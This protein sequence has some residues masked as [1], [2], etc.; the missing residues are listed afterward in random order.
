MSINIWQ[1]V[2]L[3]RGLKDWEFYWWR[4]LHSYKKFYGI[5]KVTF[6]FCDETHD[7]NGVSTY[8]DAM[9]IKVSRKF[10]NK[11]INKKSIWNSKSET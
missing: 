8:S 5:R 1:E 4:I 3:K 7:V 9:L 10:L 2:M 6:T 11:F